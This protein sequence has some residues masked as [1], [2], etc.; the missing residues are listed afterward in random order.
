MLRG[1]IIGIGKIAQEGHM[2]AFLDPALASAGVSIVAAVDN[3]DAT[4]KMAKAKFPGITYYRTIEEMYNNEDVDFIDICSPPDTHARI[5]E[6]G[7]QKGV[8]I[9]CEKPFVLKADDAERL[10]KRI[11]ESPNV[12]MPV[13]Q[14][15]YSPIWKRFKDEISAG[16][17]AK[18]I[19]QFN[20]FRTEADNGIASVQNRWR[21]D[22]TVSGGGILS[23]TGVHYLYLSLW[24]LGKVNNVTSRILSI[25]HTEYSVEDTALVILESEHGVAQISLT[26]GADRRHNSA[27]LVN[28]TGSL[29]YNGTELVK[30]KPGG[31]SEKIPVPDASDKRNYVSLYVSL[32][33]EFLGQITRG[34][35]DN[36]HLD[37]AYKS[38]RLLHSC[39]RAAE[40]NQTVG[41]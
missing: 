13:H 28:S 41:L 22:P 27:V 10:Y 7:L 39:Y 14:Y 25:S 34:Q 23:D 3:N 11:S 16:L 20:V 32:L 17:E 36:C 24:L 6:E 1:A 30:H 35:K 33:R 4:I 18:S 9:L 40:L 15:K 26:W 12:F 5:I 29:I 37:E 38:I 21:T 2:P 8:H 19:L 31:G